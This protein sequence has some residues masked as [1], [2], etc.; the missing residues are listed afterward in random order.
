MAVARSINPIDLDLVEEGL[1]I[2]RKLMAEAI[3]AQDAKKAPLNDVGHLS[4]IIAKSKG[5]EA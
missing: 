4:A 5:P 2:G 3:A 1:E